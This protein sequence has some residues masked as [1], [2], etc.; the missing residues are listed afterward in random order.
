MPCVGRCSGTLIGRLEKEGS[1]RVSGFTPSRSVTVGGGYRLCLRWRNSPSIGSGGYVGHIGNLVNLAEFESRLFDMISHSQNGSHALPP[2]TLPSPRDI[3]PIFIAGIMPRSGTNFLYDLLLL[4]PDCQGGLPGEDN[5]L[6][7]VPHLLEFI[8]TL[9]KSWPP[10]WDIHRVDCRK[11]LSRCLGYG[12]LDFLA[13]E[14]N[15]P[16]D[17]LHERAGTQVVK[18]AARKKR[19]VNK[20]PSVDH[21]DSCFE[22]FPE[23][24]LLILIRDGRAIVESGMRSGFGWSFEWATRCWDWSARKV[25]EYDDRHAG[26]SQ[27]HLIVRY[28]ELF[29]S[30]EN[31]LRRIFDFVQL[32]PDVF[33]FETAMQL[34]VRGSSTFKSGERPDFFNP[35]VKTSSFKPLDR[36]KDWTQSQRDRF[37]WI[38]G[39]S[40]ERL[41][42][43]NEP[44]MRPSLWKILT[45]LLSEVRW[46]L[47]RFCI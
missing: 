32:D 42:Y 3:R 16:E 7:T 47:R 45:H 38:A 2:E 18:L 46:R 8:N 36:W 40:L 39:R 6:R 22:L 30:P 11:L 1:L 25:L 23:A 35:V 28:E 19:L 20:T 12:I 27:R 31:E 13:A 34:P 10:D 14:R 37:N 17:T 4:H 29:Q 21:L 44:H 33:D 24:Y 41:G 43:Q 5:V 9:T 15:S 26:P